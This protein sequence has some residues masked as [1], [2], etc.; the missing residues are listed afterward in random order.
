MKIKIRNRIFSI[1]EGGF[2]DIIILGGIFVLTSILIIGL[3]PDKQPDEV[4]LNELFFYAVMTIPV[5]AA[6]YFIFVSFQRNLYADSPHIGSSIKKKISLVFIF[7]A[8]IPV[9]TVV[10]TSNYILHYSLSDLFFDR[11]AASLRESLRMTD[12]S[13]HELGEQVRTS[14]K[15]MELRGA[16]S[17]VS[18]GEAGVLSESGISVYASST[19][20]SGRSLRLIANLPAT[21]KAAADAESLSQF[22]SSVFNLSSGRIDRLTLNGRDC[23]AG[24]NRHGAHL[25]VLLKEVPGSL[26]ERRALFARSVNDNMKLEYLKGYYKEGAG[27]FLFGLSIF[28]ILLSAGLSILLSTSITKPVLDLAEASKRLA[29]GDFNVRLYRESEDE[30][31]LL[32]KSFNRMVSELDQNRRL[33]YQKQRLEAWREVARRVVHEIKNP[34]TPIR[35]SAE[36]MRKRYIEGHPDIEK[37]ILTGT[38][39]IVE[40]VESLMNLLNEFTKFAR[41]PEMKPESV[42]LNNLLHACASIF[43]AHEGVSIELKLDPS[44]PPVKLDKMLIRQSLINIIQ[45]AIDALQHEGKITINSSLSDNPYSRFVRIGIADNGPGI[46]E[47]ELENIFEPGFSTKQSGSGLGLAIV[48]KIILEHSGTISCSSEPGSG[49]EFVIELPVA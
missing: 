26:N 42:D 14:L 10:I 6:V 33:T 36:R 19:E 20:G 9:L 27:V 38:E 29:A 49:T 21:G 43:S 41:L 47:D 4:A 46:K 34:L 30:L 12:E 40:E 2:Q 37:I 13:L 31:G 23:I 24:V 22:Y 5:I 32:F 17:S 28:V 8:I 7:I 45:N 16:G 1:D 15:S 48:E 11:T 3:F 39:T 25:T 18:R 44:I 35:L